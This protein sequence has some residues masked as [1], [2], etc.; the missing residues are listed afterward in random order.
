MQLPRL[1]PRHGRRHKVV[2]L[3]LVV[4]LLVVVL[5]VVGA[6]GLL[7]AHTMAAGLVHTVYIVLAHAHKYTYIYIYSYIYV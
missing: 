4:V 3:P 2:V 6:V 5:L 7:C 1:R